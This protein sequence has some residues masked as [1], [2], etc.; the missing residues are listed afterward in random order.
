MLSISKLISASAVDYAAEELKKYLRMMMPESGDITV[1]YNPKAV[2]GFR[3]GLMQD[4]GLDVSDVENCELDDILYID[5][6]ETGGIIA[7]DN[8]RSVLL[9]VYEYLRQ[10]GCR[11]LFPGVDGELIP[12]KNIAPVKYRFVPSC[13]FRG[14]CNEGAEFQQS[15]LAAIE[16]MP[17][18]GMNTMMMEFRNPHT[19]YS[20]YYN[21]V[22]NEKN[23]PP[24][25]VSF[26]TT[27]QWKRMCETELQKRGLMFHDIGHG[28]TVD[29][30][31]IDSTHAWYRVDDSVIPD[32]QRKYLAL[33]DGKRSFYRGQPINTQFCMSNPE[34]RAIVAKYVA[35]Y[36]Q[37]HSNADYLHVWL[38]DSSNNHCECDE[39]KKLIP[40][41]WYMLLMNEIDEE[42]TKRN[43]NTRIVFIVYI[44][45]VWAPLVHKIKNQE[46]FSAMVAPISRSYTCTLA[47]LPADFKP[48]PFSLN[49]NIFPKNLSEF[50][51]YY[52]QWKKSWDGSAFCYE[53]H[54]WRHQACELSGTALAKRIIEDVLAYKS[55]GINGVIEDGSQR[56]FFP[57][58]FAFYTYARIL[59]DNSL[60]YRELAEEYYSAAYGEDWRDFLNYFERLGAV[61]DQKYLEGERSANPAVCAYYNP[62]YLNNLDQAEKILLEGEELVKGHYNSDYRARTA[63]VRLMEKHIEYVRGFIEI[64]RRKAVGD[65]GEAIRLLDGFCR[66]FGRH[67]P[68]I[69]LCY[70]HLIYTSSLNRIMRMHP[71]RKQNEITTL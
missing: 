6:D 47:E 2:S 52:K 1:S 27:L 71:S 41:D 32:G 70:D 51:E 58:G 7:G 21:H 12:I 35:D 59:F 28:F 15:M 26:D 55:H 34:A 24:E 30:F 29:P 3:L 20:W 46:R 16:F 14:Q 4:F 18:I 9:S 33:C 64:F 53:Y 39:C 22:G 43:L 45:T 61:L 62:D 66:S 23:R 8:P 49:R 5:C 38:A 65:D 11:W 37:N 19:Y 17:K 36:A 13:R 25:P 50:L 68:E 48:S 10:N 63:S 67:E 42:L 57:N 44:D 56:S 54:F 69:E 40:S 60:T 31:G